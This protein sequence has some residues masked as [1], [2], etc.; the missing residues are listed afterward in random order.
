[1]G[2]EDYILGGRCPYRT[3]RIILRHVRPNVIASRG[4]RDVDRR[5]HHRCSWLELLGVWSKAANA[6]VGGDAA[7]G[8][9]VHAHRV[10]D[11]SLSR[12]VHHHHGLWV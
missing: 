3:H 5:Q 11:G 6:I 9:R 7:A 1:V 10:V 4:D 2:E 8:A 12:T